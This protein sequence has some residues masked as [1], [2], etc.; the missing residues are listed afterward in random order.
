[1]YLYE[2]SCSVPVASCVHTPEQLSLLLLN[3]DAAQCGSLV[4]RCA[5]TQTP[6]PALSLYRHARAHRSSMCCR[7]Y[8]TTQPEAACA[9]A[10]QQR[11]RPEQH[12]LPTLN[13]GA[14]RRVLYL[15]RHAHIHRSSWSCR[16]SQRTGTACCHRVRTHPSE[17]PCASS[18]GTRSHS[19]APCAA[20]P[21]VKRRRRTLLALA[22]RWRKWFACGNSHASS[23]CLAH[24]PNPRPARDQ[25]T[26]STRTHSQGYQLDTE[27]YHSTPSSVRLLTALRTRANGTCCFPYQRAGGNGLHHLRLQHH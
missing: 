27:Q 7:S 18:V 23:S 9:A 11:R 14:T 24:E 1:M 25:H 10:P 3:D 8:A 4:D 17:K 2:Y 21:P 16:P 19:E 6:G 15:W 22:A 5:Y 13:D 26:S 12:V 20:A